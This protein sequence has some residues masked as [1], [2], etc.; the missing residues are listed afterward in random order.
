[1]IQFER[2]DFLQLARGFLMGGADIIPG[3]S[4]GTVALIL[5]IYERLVGA[6]SH[7]D[8][9]LIALAIQRQWRAA[10][11]YLD[12]RFLLTLGIGIL[13]GIAC[14]ARLMHYLLLEQR[15][16]T[17]AVFFG[18]ILASSYVVMRLVQPQNRAQRVGCYLLAAVAAIFAYWLVGLEQ[19]GFHDHLGS[20]FL[21]GAIAICAMILPGI[22]GSYILWL[23]GAYVAVTGIIKDVLKFDCTQ[24]EFIS[25]LTFA[26]GCACGLIGFS[27]LLKWLLARA[28]MP[29]MAILG[30]FMI[31]SL[32][33]MWP[34]QVD[35]TPETTE[36][37]A[38]RYAQ[39]MP[40]SWDHDV[41]TCLLFALGAMALV[42]ILERWG[43]VESL[44]RRDDT[45]A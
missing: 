32:R 18:L 4:G 30:G 22:S 2:R 37:K 39:L 11:E 36:L 26:A 7:V 23:L 12:F 8:G 44:E 34:F 3:V 19:V 21:C 40:E 9:H 17:L 43:S 33:L 27:K 29:I 10:A 6:I 20:F 38:K 5:G 1:M 31:G 15:M 13:T 16:Y 41:T 25:L 28:H 14:L 24:R 35:L 45:L 42:L